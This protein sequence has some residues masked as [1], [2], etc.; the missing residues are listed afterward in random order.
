MSI[1]SSAVLQQ[2][3]C[4]EYHSELKLRT[5]LDFFFFLV[6]MFLGVILRPPLPDLSVLVAP[7]TCR[8]LN[9][10]MQSVPGVTYIHRMGSLAFSPQCCSLQPEFLVSLFTVVH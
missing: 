9:A 10:W 5:C 7:S 8:T 2:T 6:V 3:F 1:K 4:Q